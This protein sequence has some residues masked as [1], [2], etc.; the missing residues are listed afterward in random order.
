[1]TKMLDRSEAIV[2]GDAPPPPIARLIGFELI[3]VKPGEAIIEFQ[4]T[5]AHANPMGKRF[6]RASGHCDN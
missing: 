5:E 2:R 4:G 3:S 6:A 1:M